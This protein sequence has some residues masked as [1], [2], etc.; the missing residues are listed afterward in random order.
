VASHFGHFVLLVLN[1]R[2]DIIFYFFINFKM[3]FME[4]ELAP[5]AVDEL[6]KL[7]C[8]K[9]ALMGRG[10]LNTVDIPDVVNSAKAIYQLVKQEW[11]TLPQ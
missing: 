1:K 8:I 4:K 5:G 2:T 6:T 7:E 3:F 11:P 10:K 9:I